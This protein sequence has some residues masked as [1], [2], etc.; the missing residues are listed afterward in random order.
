MIRLDN[1]GLNVYQLR[2]LKSSKSRLTLRFGQ[3]I[4]LIFDPCIHYQIASGF[5]VREFRFHRLECESRRKVNA[6]EADPDFRG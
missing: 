2:N 5:N 4:A 1:S 6:L 3:A